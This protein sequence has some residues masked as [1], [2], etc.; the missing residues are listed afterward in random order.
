MT[1]TPRPCGKGGKGYATAR[2]GRRSASKLLKT[3][4]KGSSRSA[5]R[6]PAPSLQSRS[7]DAWTAA[8]PT[9]GT[10]TLARSFRSVRGRRSRSGDRTPADVRRTSRG[11]DP[12]GA[13]AVRAR[14]RRF[15]RQNNFGVESVACERSRGSL[16]RPGGS[17]H[18]RCFTPSVNRWHRRPSRM[19][20]HSIH[21]SPN[22]NSRHFRKEIV[23]RNFIYSITLCALGF[24]QVAMVVIELT[25]A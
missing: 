19:T 6:G 4:R 21:L 5:F 23:M 2:A 7:W 9:V 8:N 18:T 16:A 12:A 14:R 17:W 10:R 24:M 3:R 13:Y 22:V 11:R 1:C 15:I 25:R 20:W